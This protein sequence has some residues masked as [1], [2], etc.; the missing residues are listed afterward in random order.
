MKVR[1][2][3]ETFIF[4]E[5]RVLANLTGD[6]VVFPGGGIDVNESPKDA[7]K[8]ECREEA[9]RRLINVTV[10]HAPTMQFWPK[11]YAKR[12]GAKWADGYEGGLTYWFTGSTSDAPLSEKHRDYEPGFAWHHS[13]AVIERLK[14]DAGGDW[15][16]DVKVRIKV[17]ETHLAAGQAI[18]PTKKS[19]RT[20]FSLPYPTLQTAGSLRDA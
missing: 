10:A 11:S 9:A 1:P 17:L 20:L 3:A 16:D 8:R 15:G 5:N 19:I 6:H 2:R 12:K 13:K 4:K 14:K 18:S 7:A